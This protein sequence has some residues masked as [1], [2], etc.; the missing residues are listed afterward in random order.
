[1]GSHEQWQAEVLNIRRHHETR[2]QRGPQVVGRK[3]RRR[4]QRLRTEPHRNGHSPP[5]PDPQPPLRS[6]VSVARPPELPPQLGK[7]QFLEEHPYVAINFILNGTQHTR[8]LVEPFPPEY[9][10]HQ[11]LRHAADALE[12][13]EQ[14]N[15]PGNDWEKATMRNQVA[16]TARKV[17]AGVHSMTDEQVQALF[18]ELLEAELSSLIMVTALNIGTG[19]DPDLK[20]V[21]TD[22]IDFPQVTIHHEDALRVLDHAAG[23]L[24]PTTMEH[25]AK[26]MGFLPRELGLHKTPVPAEHK[27]RIMLAAEKAQ[28]PHAIIRTL[29]QQF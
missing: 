23:K 15:T 10:A 13:L 27:A 18:D 7:N 22:H 20:R 8:A 9:P 2:H 4:H 19:N 28:I 12:M 25:V 3:R 17:T 24:S 11:V 5:L 29:Q 21:V 26:A 16:L 14:G 6:P 1:M